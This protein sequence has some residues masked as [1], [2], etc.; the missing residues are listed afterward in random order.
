MR[1]FS[2]FSGIS[3]A[4]AAWK[5]LGFE[6][7]GYCEPEAFQSLVLSERCGATKPRYLPDYRLGRP[8]DSPIG[9]S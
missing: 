2:T 3:A 9:D 4:T 7:V 6:F 8:A 5:R 1:V